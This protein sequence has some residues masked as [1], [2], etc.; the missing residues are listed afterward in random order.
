VEEGGRWHARSSEGEG[1]LV[2]RRSAE[3]GDHACWGSDMRRVSWAG[4]RKRK[5][6]RPK[7]IVQD[8]YVFKEF[9]TDSNLKWSKGCLTILKK[10]Q[11]KYE[12]VGNYIRN[13]FPYWNFSKFGI[14]FE[15]KSMKF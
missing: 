10:L 12:F 7:E 8:F 13:N 11:I 15:L 4:L 14:E 3:A 2:G 1:R 5:M 6:A 9:S